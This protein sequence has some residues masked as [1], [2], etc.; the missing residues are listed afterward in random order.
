MKEAGLHGFD[1][2]AFL[3]GND[4]YLII[5]Q[6][7]QHSREIAKLSNKPLHKLVPEERNTFRTAA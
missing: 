5:K 6:G 1:E 2:W 7:S 4:I 3:P